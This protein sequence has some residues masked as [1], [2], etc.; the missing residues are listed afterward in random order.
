LKWEKA[1]K[2]MLALVV[3]TVIIPDEAGIVEALVE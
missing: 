3:T 2:N 1:H